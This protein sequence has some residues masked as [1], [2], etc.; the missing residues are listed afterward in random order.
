MINLA[1]NI[2]ILY[3]QKPYNWFLRRSVENPRQIQLIEQFIDV[4]TCL[5]LNTTNEDK[6]N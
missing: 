1:F 5:L 6:D 3:I 2:N 4:H